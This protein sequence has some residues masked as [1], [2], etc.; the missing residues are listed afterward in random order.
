MLQERQLNI[1]KVSKLSL[2]IL[3]LFLDENIVSTKLSLPQSA[4]CCSDVW[5]CPIYQLY[6]VLS[7]KS[8][9]V[10][11]YM[12]RT[13]GPSG[14]MTL[15]IRT[16]TKAYMNAVV[17]VVSSVNWRILVSRPPLSMIY[18]WWCYGRI[19]DEI[20][21]DLPSKYLPDIIEREEEFQ[22]SERWT[23]VNRPMCTL[24]L[25]PLLCELATWG[26]VT[27]SDVK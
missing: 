19:D 10:L 1:V 22:W 17:T 26:G 9:N 8:I 2:L 4:S 6:L 3:F 11:P 23:I 13:L 27:W 5:L 20:D 12:N 14:K 16:Q 7:S 21:G 25:Q 18:P 24:L 15:A